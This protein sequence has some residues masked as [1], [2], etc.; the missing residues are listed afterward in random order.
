MNDALSY[1]LDMLRYEQTQTEVATTVDD[2][3]NQRASI[4]RRWD[5][6]EVPAH[7]REMLATLA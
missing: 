5:R 1:E 6:E 4:V 7:E 3:I 2:R